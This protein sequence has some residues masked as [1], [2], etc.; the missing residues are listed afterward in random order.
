MAMA[1]KVNS[2]EASVVSTGNPWVSWAPAVGPG[3]TCGYG[4]VLGTV[5]PACENWAPG[6]WCV[7]DRVGDVR[8]AILL[9]V[10]CENTFL[11]SECQS[12]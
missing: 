11:T 6:T 4:A 8:A 3:P 2:P 12:S 10:L 1:S 7:M 5:A 9:R